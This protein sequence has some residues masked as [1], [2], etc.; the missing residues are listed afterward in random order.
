MLH[1]KDVFDL[2]VLHILQAVDLVDMGCA[3]CRYQAGESSPASMEDVDLGVAVFLATEHQIHQCMDL[4]AVAD[5]KSSLQK[6]SNIIRNAKLTYYG[7]LC[8]NRKVSRRVTCQPFDLV[9]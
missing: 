7:V 9:R 5:I 1:L 2:I 4:P 3:F 6:G 8:M